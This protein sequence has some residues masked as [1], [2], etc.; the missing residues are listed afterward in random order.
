MPRCGMCKIPTARSLGRPR[1]SRAGSTM[2]GRRGTSRRCSRK[3]KRSRERAAAATRKGRMTPRNDDVYWLALS[4]LRSVNTFDS[5]SFS[6]SVFSSSSRFTVAS[7]SLSLSLSKLSLCSP[8]CSP[9]L[10]LR[11][12]PSESSASK[13]ASTSPGF[14]STMR[15][16]L[17]QGNAGTSLSNMASAS[18]LASSSALACTSTQCGALDLNFLNG[19]NGLAFASPACLP[20]FSPRKWGGIGTTVACTTGASRLKVLTRSPLPR[21]HT[22]I[23]PSSLPEIRLCPSPEHARDVTAPAC[24]IRVLP[25]ASPS[26]FDA[27]A[28][29][30]ALR[31][32]SKILPSF[33]PR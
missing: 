25:T 7:S 1:S 28:P 22:W 4:L 30:S 19:L 17:A 10:Q 12:F 16:M 2:T 33:P 27:M 9:P 5:N 13:A 32:F 29:G 23:T 31:T 14:A 6:F 11:G 3:P 21:F 24:P 20:R 15:R 18:S 26:A 8:T